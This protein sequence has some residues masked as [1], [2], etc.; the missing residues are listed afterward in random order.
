MSPQSTPL[1]SSNTILEAV[2]GEV[3]NSRL[4]GADFTEDHGDDST[5]FEVRRITYPCKHNS[6][7]EH[8]S[9]QITLK[10]KYSSSHRRQ[11]RRLTVQAKRLR[12]KLVRGLRGTQNGAA[13]AFPVSTKSSTPWLTTASTEPQGSSPGCPATAA[14]IGLVQ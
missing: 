3:K 4:A 11:N 2:A 7:A 5:I 10:I 12:V 14:V 8:K 1:T 9:N 13:T 6:V